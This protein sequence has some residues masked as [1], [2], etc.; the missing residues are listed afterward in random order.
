MLTL[1]K[2]AMIVLCLIGVATPAFAQM[3][4]DPKGIPMESNMGANA[5]MGMSKSIPM[6]KSMPESTNMGMGKGMAKSDM[7]YGG[8]DGAY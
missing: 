3:Y 2:T 1:L 5:N 4:G 7:G 8:M 6:G